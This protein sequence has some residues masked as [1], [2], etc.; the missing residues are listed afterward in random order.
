MKF[1][2]NN[3]NIFAST[4]GRP[5]D[6]NKPLII[7]V[8][9]SGLTHMCW[10]LQ[11]RSFA[12]HGYSV[13]ALDL[14]GHGLSGGNS[15]QSIE[16]MAE[17]ISDVID[18][19]DFKEASLVGHSQG[20]LIT[21]ECAARY[22]EKIKTLSLMGGAGAIPIN[23]ELLSLAE[24]NDSK[25]VDLMMDFAHGPSGHFGGHPVPGLH[26]LNIGSMLVQSREVKDTLGVDF[27][28]CQNYTNGFNAAKKI[29]LPT[30][31]ILADQ[32]RM[33]RVKDGKKLADHIK[34]SEVYIIENCGHMMLLEEA[35]K[36]LAILKKFI[37]KNYPAY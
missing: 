22:P 8:H 11:T 20:C 36:T 33:C 15:L 27:R 1:K 24:N 30:L 5:L 31:S 19:V 21:V 26:H 6:K 34:N 7:F 17:W 3:E 12:F 13:L 4:G 9:G 18:A 16:E 28:A 37:K 35:D 23:L 2:V 14:P 32:D 29:N 25:A 10:V